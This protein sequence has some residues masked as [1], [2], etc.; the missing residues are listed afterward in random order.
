MSASAGVRVLIVEDHGL[1]AD[2][3]STA[4]GH[5]G[6]EVCRPSAL[7]VDS[8]LSEAEIFRPHVALLD[9][10]L[11]NDTSALPMIEPLRDLGASVV[12]VTG[13]RNQVALAECVEA[14]AIGLVDKSRPF[15]DL[16]EAVGHVAE[17]RTIL[18]RAERDELLR[19]LREQRLADA[20]RHAPF[21]RMTAREQQVLG[22]LMEGLSAEA[23]ASRDYVSIATVRT[24][25]RAVLSKLGVSSQLA[26]VALARAAEWEP[27]DA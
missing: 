23:I 25:I 13:E 20:E 8:V 22:G 7:D 24:Q 14:G 1:L 12:M 21:D 5:E 26:A 2:S 10:R 4:L 27:P 15:E 16:V 17:L 6:Y 9:L 19:M 11:E 18:S 3:L